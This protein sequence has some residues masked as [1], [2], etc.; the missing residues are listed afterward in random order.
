[1]P[2]SEIVEVDATPKR[3]EPDDISRNHIFRAI[4]DNGFEDFDGQSFWLQVEPVKLPPYAVDERGIAQL[5]HG[6]VDADPWNG[7]TRV[8]PGFKGCKGMVEHHLAQ[9]FEQT[10]VLQG[11]QKFVWRYE[12]LYGVLPPRQNLKA[13]DLPG[14][15]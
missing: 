14:F 10:G 8:V 7:Q 11:R 2:S 5:I 15:G 3:A 4:A 12:S 6:E 9:P 13:R 1:M